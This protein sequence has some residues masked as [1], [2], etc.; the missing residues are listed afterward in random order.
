VFAT[1]AYGDESH[2]GVYELSECAAEVSI[3]AAWRSH[4]SGASPATSADPSA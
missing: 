4:V 3:V 1:A 2:L